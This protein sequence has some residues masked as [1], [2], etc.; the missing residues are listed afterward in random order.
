[1]TVG[2]PARRGQELPS[3]AARGAVGPEPGGGSPLVPVGGAA[4]GA[5]AGPVAGG[6]AGGAPGA[7]TARMV[8]PK[9]APTPTTA[10]TISPRV[11]TVEVLAGTGGSIQ[12]VPMTATP[13]TTTT[14]RTPSPAERSQRAPGTS[15]P[16][17]RRAR[18]RRGTVLAI[19]LGVGLGVGLGNG[20]V[21]GGS[22]A[23]LGDLWGGGPAAAAAAKYYFRLHK[24]EATV[25][26]NP[27]IKEITAEAL[28]AE[29]AARPEWQSDLGVGDDR[30][31]LVAELKKR[32]LS[33]FDLIVKIVQLK[34][35]VKDPAPGSR[36][37]Q[38]AV[39]VRLAVL[40]TAI[41]GEKIAFSGEGEAAAEAA[42]P[43][44]R[45]E[46]EATLM[47]KDAI[48]SAVAQAID[49]AVLKL[50]LPQSA[51]LNE[52]KRKRKKS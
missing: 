31:A 23:T 45:I 8:L 27:D 10:S 22:P 26:V 38:L 12:S 16:S 47:F 4:A 7:T 14:T 1:V 20:R 15:P 13:P 44:R 3:F 41:P 33:G 28:K 39:S 5:G 24:V 43:E 29:L 30:D 49:Q 48:K 42:V 32:R 51:P 9:M 11:T 35:E 6:A 40:G 50:S 17:P 34:K 46:D 2:Q 18:S 25:P 19:G 52:S 21:D 37:H 36:N